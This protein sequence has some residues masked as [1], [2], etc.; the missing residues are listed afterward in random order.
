[1]LKGLPP[2]GP[3]FVV[4]GT[5][6]EDIEAGKV[7]HSRCA[8]QPHIRRNGVAVTGQ[9]PATGQG[10]EGVPRRRSKELVTQHRYHCAKRRIEK[11]GHDN[12]LQQASLSWQ[13]TH[14]TGVEVAVAL[15]SSNTPP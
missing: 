15:H 12:V 5:P 4:E 3:A 6:E 1:M 9:G 13:M 10:G 2:K 11:G 7:L 14:L 8:G